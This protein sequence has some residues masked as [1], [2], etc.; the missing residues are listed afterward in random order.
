MYK[1]L[2]LVSLGLYFFFQ[3]T[4]SAL[5]VATMVRRNN[6]GRP[7][8][9]KPKF[10]RGK[11]STD[12]LAEQSP[13]TTIKETPNDTPGLVSKRLVEDSEGFRFENVK[14]SADFD[15]FDTSKKRDYIWFVNERG[16]K[17]DTPGLVQDSS[18]GASKAVEPVHITPS[19]PAYPPIP[20]DI[21]LSN[22]MPFPDTGTNI[23]PKPDPRYKEIPDDMD[24]WY[25]P[26]EDIL[27]PREEEPEPYLEWIEFY[28]KRRQ[29]ILDGEELSYNGEPITPKEFRRKL[30]AAEKEIDNF[31]RQAFE[32]E[33]KKGVISQNETAPAEYIKELK[34]LKAAKIKAFKAKLAAAKQGK[35]DLAEDKAKS[36][37]DESP[38]VSKGQTEL[39]SQP[40][41]EE[42]VIVKDGVAVPASEANV[43]E[44]EVVKPVPSIVEDEA[45]L[46]TF[47]KAVREG[48]LFEVIDK[49][50]FWWYFTKMVGFFWTVAVLFAIGYFIFE[51][52]HSRNL[53]GWEGRVEKVHRG[54]DWQRYN[55]AHPKPKKTKE[56]MYLEEDDQVRAETIKRIDEQLYKGRKK[57]LDPLKGDMVEEF[58]QEEEDFRKPV[59]DP[60]NDNTPVPPDYKK[61]TLLAI[62]FVASI[63]DSRLV[64]LLRR[65]FR[66]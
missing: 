18:V 17:S 15:P 39:P 34:A 33:V 21:D 11:S 43:P 12:S 26:V 41:S 64:A 37:V 24:H 7:T 58:D 3:D 22:Y 53:M 48:R 28:Q 62:L 27:V 31:K 36:D 44:E 4:L 59:H 29:A 5:N 46:A 13:S 32:E 38:I 54:K 60:Q 9:P 8:P 20:S 57:P 56:E 50:D 25:D 19:G 66:R 14:D 63:R 47:D 2:I 30:A 42:P 35:A 55:L 6:T 40:T 65:I 51:V 1:N 49:I 45:E 52:Y 10:G 16:P 23:H 61:R